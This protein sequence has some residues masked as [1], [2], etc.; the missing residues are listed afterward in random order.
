MEVGTPVKNELM[1]DLWAIR[2]LRW[3]CPAH[4]LEEI[5]GDLLQKFAHDVKLF[6]ERKARR[7]LLWNVIRFFRPGILLRNKLVLNFRQM[8]ILQN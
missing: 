7:R 3:F 2:I 1:K 8:D 5:E 6:G 4:L